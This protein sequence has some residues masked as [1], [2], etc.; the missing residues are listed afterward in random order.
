MSR[1]SWQAAAECPLETSWASGDHILSK[2]TGT[3]PLQEG[4]LALAKMS[5]IDP[6]GLQA[7]L[8][9]WPTYLQLPLKRQRNLLQTRAGGRG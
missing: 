4:Q 3:P 1:R 7:F 2:S 5:Q 9:P 6:R 8:K